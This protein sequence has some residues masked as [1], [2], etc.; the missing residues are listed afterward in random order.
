MEQRRSQSWWRAPLWTLALA[1]GAKSF[2]DNPVL[3]SRRLN[4][5]GLHARRL[6]LAHGLAARRRRALAAAVPAHWRER[7]D[8][9]GFVR[10]DEVV[11]PADF[12]ALQQRLATT[13]L[14]MRAHLQGDTVTARVPLDDGSLRQLPEIAA[15]LRRRDLRALFAYVATT[16]TPPLHYL[17][18]ILGGAVAASQADPQIELHA[19]CF[20][21]SLKAWLFLA[22]VPDDGR[23]LTYVAG[24]HRLTPERLA[25]EGHR[26]QTVL[27]D[28]DRL[29]Q[30][31]S[32]RVR[33]DEL[34]ALGLPAPTRLAVPANTLVVADMFGFHA[35]ADSDRPTTRVELWSYSRRPPFLSDLAERALGL[36]P[37]GSRRAG[38]AMRAADWLDARHLRRQHW[39]PIGDQLPAAP[40]LGGRDPLSLL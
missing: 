36:G 24:S 3:G 28:G 27:D 39:H 23:P 26:S 30:R 14:P 21:P 6:K 17:Q 2:V 18:T 31:G 7:F 19:D 12:A 8:H 1:T 34:P 10:I 20:H 22:D 38:L 11:P 4:E 40:D 5:L 25:W 33:P 29:S 35:R 15:L 32:L 9:D 37:L 16:R 13:R